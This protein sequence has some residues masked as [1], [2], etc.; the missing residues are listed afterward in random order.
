MDTE[1]YELL[2]KIFE[3]KKS[4]LALETRIAKLEAETKRTV[5]NEAALRE[6]DHS[7]PWENDKWGPPISYDAFRFGPIGGPKECS[8]TNNYDSNSRDPNCPVHK[9]K[10][11]W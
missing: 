4:N 3:I 2:L 10:T 6:F 8:C 1:I 7:D 5:Q 11:P 9:N